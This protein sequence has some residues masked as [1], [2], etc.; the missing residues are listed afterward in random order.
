MNVNLLFRW[1]NGGCRT[2]ASQDTIPFE[3]GTSLFRERIEVE[4][5]PSLRSFGEAS[6]DDVVHEPRNLLVARKIVLS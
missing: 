3:N 5:P 1:L 4:D 2:S 6:E